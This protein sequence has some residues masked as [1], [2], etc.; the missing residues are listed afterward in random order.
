MP[1]DDDPEKP[2][3]A[4]RELFLIERATGVPVGPTP[5]YPILLAAP[6]APGALRAALIGMR[7]PELLVIDRPKAAEPVKA[8]EPIDVILP[9]AVIRTPVGRGVGH[10]P[11][12][13]LL[14]SPA[15][16]RGWPFTCICGRDR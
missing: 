6:D 2:T 10:T 3:T 5:T 9:V 14:D 13:R 11:M 16:K 12:C 15:R 8:E 1:D 4:L 7:P